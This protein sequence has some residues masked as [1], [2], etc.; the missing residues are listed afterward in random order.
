LAGCAC[1]NTSPAVNAKKVP[2]N[3]IVRDPTVTR[4][5]FG[6]NLRD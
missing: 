3:F 2:S 5:A 4:R 1:A 6:R